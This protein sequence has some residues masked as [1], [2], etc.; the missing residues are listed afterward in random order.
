MQLWDAGKKLRSCGH[1]GRSTSCVAFFP[2][3]KVLVSGEGNAVRLWNPVTGDELERG[4]G[5]RDG[6]SSLV[7]VEEAKLLA[8]GGGDGTVRPVGA[9]HRGGSSAGLQV[10]PGPVGPL[11]YA[12]A[13][14]LLASGSSDEVIRLWRPATGAK[15]GEL[16]GK[17]PG[18]FS[19]MLFPRRQ[20]PGKRGPQPYHIPLGPR[21]WQG[22][23]PGGPP[24]PRWV[25]ARRLFSR[26]PHPRFRRHCPGDLPV[27]SSDR[28]ED[29][30]DQGRFGAAAAV[31]F[32]PD[33]KTLAT[34]GS[35]KVALWEVDMVHKLAELTADPTEVR[36]TAFSPTASSSPR[37][38][39]APPSAC[40]S[41]R[42]KRSWTS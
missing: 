18:V 1:G 27:G 2:D 15:T 24:R 25:L 41:G 29:S 20:D 17:L 32:T 3:G 7:F 16:A 11:A 40:G 10:H 6:V 37:G 22:N 34:S 23:P 33:G 39:K 35:N 38:A 19:F 13:S 5:H 28:P 36:C 4:N 30:Q 31:A 21:D 42:R 14:G 9:W 26:R 8:T 12:P